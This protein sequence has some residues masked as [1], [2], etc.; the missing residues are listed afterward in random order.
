VTVAVP[1]D[2]GN[3]EAHQTEAHQTMDVRHRNL[4]FATIAMGMLLG[5]L[6]QMIVSTALPTIVA[7]LGGGGHMSW[8]VTAYLLTETIAAALVG[9]FGD[10]FGRKRIYQVSCAIFVIASFFC[11]F[12]HS[13]IWLIAMRALQGIGGGGLMVTSMA[14]IADIIPLRERGRYQGAIG[15]V[16][17]VSTVVGPLLGGLITDN[18][19][20]RWVF[21]VNVPVAA[22]VI[23]VAARTLSSSRS[24]ARPLIDYRGILIVSLAAAG[25]TLATSWGG[26]SYPWTSPVIIGLFAGSA[27]ALVAFVV[28]ELRAAEPMLPM[29]LFTS[30]V[31]SLSCIMSFFVAFAMLSVMTYL[32]TFLQFV[33]GVNATSSGLR[34]LPV[35][36]GLLLT[37]TAAGSVVTRSGSY[38]LFP[39][40]GG[41]VL[42][43]GMFLLSQVGAQ[44]SVLV[45]SLDLLV[46]GSGIGLCMQVLLIVVQNTVDYRDLGVA[47][48][49]VSFFRSMGGAFG[50][51]VFGAI[52]ANQFTGRLASALATT[53]L[54]QHAVGS[55]A[56]VHLLPPT[57]SAPIIDAYAQSLHAVFL[58]GVPVAA[59]VMLFGLL[60]KQVP[61]RGASALKP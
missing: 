30:S 2:P 45:T 15:A 13:M 6:D 29:R 25:L 41:A 24:K 14:L 54:S 53:G 42:A 51:S 50:I 44:T 22:G 46:I 27:L 47:T 19:S 16:F 23:A 4:A 7:E 56:A 10:L 61:L 17:G 11:G 60:L 55:P 39:I 5:A 20:W 36:I 35:V 38:K 26:I 52:Y 40:A 37:S 3:G 58:A 28:V 57:Q 59:L 32:P 12:A 48:S 21:Y 34:T 1:D 33:Q 31:F 43:T 9:K 49:G 18:M 8:V